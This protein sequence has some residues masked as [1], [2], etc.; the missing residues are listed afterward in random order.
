MWRTIL[1][2]HVR[3]GTTYFQPRTELRSGF[4][5]D[6]R[7]TSGFRFRFGKQGI[8]N[9]P[10]F[11]CQLIS[12]THASIDRSCFWNRL[13]FNC[14]CIK[15]TSQ[16][17]S[18]PSLTLFASSRQS[19]PILNNNTGYKLWIIIKNSRILLSLLLIKMFLMGISLQIPM[20]SLF[21]VLQIIDYY[22]IQLSEN[23][24]SESSECLSNQ[25]HNGTTSPSNSLFGKTISTTQSW[26]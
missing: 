3:Q 24:I 14:D 21:M 4:F 6:L 17:G 2:R 19:G 10:S 22:H 12:R 25:S 9:S 8:N 15:K 20:R 1:S 5:S 7:R 18:F 16:P 11:V 13:F 26:F 23:C